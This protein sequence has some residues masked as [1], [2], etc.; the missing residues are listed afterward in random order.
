VTTISFISA[1]YVAACF[2]AVI[3]FV[4]ASV[5]AAGKD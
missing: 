3:A 1:L 2:G 4:I 5:L